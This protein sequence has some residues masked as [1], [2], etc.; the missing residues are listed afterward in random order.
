MSTSYTSLLGLALPATGE[1]SGTWGTLVNSSITNL[2]DSAVAGT[3]TISTDADKVLVPS[4]SGA[5]DDARQAILL[6][7]AGGT[8]TRYISAPSQSKVYVVINKTSST[9]SIVLRGFSGTSPS[10]SYTTGVTIV[11]GEYAVCAWNGVDFVKTGNYSVSHS[12]TMNN[13]GSGAVSGSLFDGSVAQTISYNTIGAF[14]SAGGTIT[15]DS[16]IAGRFG[17]GLANPLRLYTTGNASY[18]DIY[19]NGGTITT[20]ADISA[21]YFTSSSGMQVNNGAVYRMYNSGNTVSAYMAYSGTKIFFTAPYGGD[22][23]YP[24]CRNTVRYTSGNGTINPGQGCEFLAIDCNLT[25]ATIVFPPNAVDG[26][27]FMVGLWSAF[28]ANGLSWS[29]SG[30]NVSSV[31]SSLSSITAV[32][33]IYVAATTSWF[34]VS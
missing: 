34:R 12:L 15:G 23:A 26:Q 32:S 5:A 11:A 17:I 25:S 10:Y 28:S 18:A 33:W 31:P 22:A 13:S 14:P 27:K 29:Y 1:E 9:Q 19:N 6:W 21:G 16:Y 2:L 20:G 24:M 8:A 3:T 7:T 4:T 30:Y